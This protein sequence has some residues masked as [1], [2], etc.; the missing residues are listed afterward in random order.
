MSDQSM[1]TTTTENV[2]PDVPN[3]PTGLERSYVPAFYGPR[4]LA[5]G[6]QAAY[7][8]EQIDA[9]T[10]AREIAVPVLSHLFTNEIRRAR[11]KRPLPIKQLRRKIGFA[12]R[13]RRMLRLSNS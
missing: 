3:A 11:G 4:D 5:G 2:G 12:D 1:G 6:L 10:R 9:E 7:E 8:R 13:L